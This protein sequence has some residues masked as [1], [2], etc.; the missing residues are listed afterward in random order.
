MRLFIG[1]SF[2]ALMFANAASASAQSIP[3][4]NWVK[5]GVDEFGYEWSVDKNSIKLASDGLVHF[6]DYDKDKF[7]IGAVDCQR[8]IIY[9]PGYDDAGIYDPNW[10]DKGQAVSPGSLGEAELQYVC[11]NAQ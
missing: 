9:P 2:A 8:R 3:A 10:R 5:I 1:L 11:A 7:R 4:S 6:E